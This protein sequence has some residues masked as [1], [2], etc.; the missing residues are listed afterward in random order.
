M[1]FWLGM[2]TEDQ[3]PYP[4]LVR[5]IQQASY[6]LYFRDRPVCERPEYVVDHGLDLGAMLGNAS[7]QILMPEAKADAVVR[8]ERVPTVLPDDPTNR[9]V[10]IRKMTNA[11]WSN[12]L[13]AISA[14]EGRAD[15]A[16]GTPNVASSSKSITR[17]MLRETGLSLRQLRQIVE[18][19]APK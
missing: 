6:D 18:E 4:D 11:S 5:A 10:A 13:K 8:R 19:V 14:L 15:V 9:V 2:L 1:P 3:H 17:R 12:I 7:I 16:F